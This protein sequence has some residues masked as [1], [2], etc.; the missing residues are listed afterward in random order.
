MFPAAKQ[1][2]GGHKFKDDRG[3]KTLRPTT[4]TTTD[5]QQKNL[6]HDTTGV[7]VVSG[8]HRESSGIPVQLNQS[9]SVGPTYCKHMLAMV[10]ECIRIITNRMA[11]SVQSEQP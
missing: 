8:G 1:R 4:Q 11:S 9:C 7:F 6:F 5:V 3:M 2:L 10:R